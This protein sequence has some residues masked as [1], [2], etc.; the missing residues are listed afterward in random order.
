M[1]KYQ[2]FVTKTVSTYFYLFTDTWYLVS[3]TS[4][5]MKH[6]YP[7]QSISAS[8]KEKQ[9]DIQNI[10]IWLNHQP[11][12]PPI[13][14][15]FILLFLHSC[16]YSLERTKDTID[17]YFTVRAQCSDLFKG[18]DAKFLMEQ[19]EI[20]DMM[21]LPTLTPDKYR[22]VMYRLRDDDVNKFNY[23]AAL[24]TFFAVNDMYISE[25]GLM[26][27]YVVVFDMTGLS[28]GYLAKVSTQ[29]SLV[30]NF[31]VYIQDCHPVR[32]K[33]IH[34]INTYPLID[35]ILNL[36]KPMMHGNLLEMIHLHPTLDTLSP[37]FPISLLPADY[38]GGKSE[39]VQVHQGKV[40]EVKRCCD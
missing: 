10:R 2:L 15:E 36:I 14:D 39:A 27:G 40:T 12:I 24:R 31:M 9:G 34:I 28:F 38:D 30:R 5:I 3:H 21:G 25:D 19:L 20:Y 18:R 29:L 23:P 26:D 8:T 22:I 35:K 11:H 17:N 16:Y 13:S 6:K 33:A 32:L 1:E 37:F 4:Y 7:F